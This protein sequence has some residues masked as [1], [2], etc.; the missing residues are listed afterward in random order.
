MKWTILGTGFGLLVACGS[1]QSAENFPRTTSAAD[2]EAS[3]SQ[4]NISDPSALPRR[5]VAT[6]SGFMTL[7]LPL[8]GPARDVIGDLDM[9]ADFGAARNQISGSASNFDG[10]TGDLEIRGGD[11]DRGTDT[12]TD[13]TFDGS[14]TGTLA[15]NGDNYAIDGS[16]VGEFRGRNQDG[17][18]GQVMATSPVRRDKTCSKAAWRPP[19]TKNN[20]PAYNAKQRANLT[21]VCALKRLVPLA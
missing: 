20:N 1:S 19:A 6:Y 8:D 11:I 5:G 2:L 9:R 4:E 13:F 14:L 7:A 17:L 12:R 10:M 3:L 18:T 15:Q 21:A 16:L